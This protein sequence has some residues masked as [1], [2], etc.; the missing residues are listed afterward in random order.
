MMAK[1]NCSSSDLCSCMAKANLVGSACATTSNNLKQVEGS[2]IQY[3]GCYHIDTS[4][5]P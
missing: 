3:T 2:S 1:A 5:C 4:S